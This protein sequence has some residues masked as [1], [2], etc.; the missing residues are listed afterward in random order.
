MAGW[1]GNREEHGVEHATRARHTG[2]VDH[3]YYDE[4]RLNLQLKAH[5]YHDGMRLR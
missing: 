5:Q 1:G 2:I 4:M 3:Q